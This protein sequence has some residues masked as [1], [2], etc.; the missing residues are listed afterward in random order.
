[1]AAT[2]ELAGEVAECCKKEKISPLIKRTSCAGVCKAT[3]FQSSLQLT[4]F[5]FMSIFV[6]GQSVISV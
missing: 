3:Y 2:A 6:S 5:A 4:K 1:M